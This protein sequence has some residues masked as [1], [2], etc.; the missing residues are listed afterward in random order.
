[1]TA[2]SRQH[3]VEGPRD[4]GVAVVGGLLMEQRGGRG[5]VTQPVAP[6][7]AARVAVWRSSCGR[8]GG[9]PDCVGGS[10]EGRAPVVAREIAAGTR[11]E[12]EGVRRSRDV[13]LQVFRQYRRHHGRRGHRPV[14]ASVWS[15]PTTL[16]PPTRRTERSTQPAAV[17]GRR[18]GAARSSSIQHAVLQEA[19]PRGVICWD[20]LAGT[21][22]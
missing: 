17:Q 15:S 16:C 12:Q 2:C 3:G 6:V 14:S 8:T 7:A 22:G 18:T 9:N 4:V 1:V 5:G 11:G 13:L 21:S 19:H 10:P 20:Y